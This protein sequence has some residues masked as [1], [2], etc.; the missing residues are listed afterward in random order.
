MTTDFNGSAVYAMVPG[1]REHRFRLPLDRASMPAKT[2][3]ALDVVQQATKAAGAATTPKAQQAASEAVR[4][5]VADLY[6]RAASTSR[7]GREHH[8][9]GYAYAA[10]KFNRAI[11]EAQAALQLLAD[12][13]QQFSNP[14]GIGFP[15][16]V[17]ANPPVMAQLHLIDDSFKSLPAVPDLEA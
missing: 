11:G 9:E 1:D 16:D 10:A 8:R 17:R 4:A 2:V 14:A 15:E 12:H 6:D 7:A 5:A 3:D 13:A